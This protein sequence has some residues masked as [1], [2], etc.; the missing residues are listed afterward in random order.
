MAGYAYTSLHSHGFSI[1]FGVWLIQV[2]LIGT[3]WDFFP[4]KYFQ[5]IV[6][7]I[8][9]CETHRY[10]VPTVFVYLL[11]LLYLLIEIHTGDIFIILGVVFFFTMTASFSYP[12]RLSLCRWLPSTDLGGTCS[13]ESYARCCPGWPRCSCWWRSMHGRWCAFVG[14]FF[15]SLPLGH[16]AHSFVVSQSVVVGLHFMGLA[17]LH[18][19]ISL[20]QE[21]SNNH[22][23]QIREYASS[24][25]AAVAGGRKS[26][27]YF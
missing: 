17:A 18:L 23:L 4:P 9:R 27:F 11:I 10:G 19:R 5:S 6:G 2:L 14:W 16:H 25:L 7:W 21:T 3:F 15:T 26:H 20:D 22:P 1:V 12:G 8:R 24:P 13:C